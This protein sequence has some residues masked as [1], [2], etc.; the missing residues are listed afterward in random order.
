[1]RAERG[2][3]GLTARIVAIAALAAVVT[4]TIGGAAVVLLARAPAERADDDPLER[5]FSAHVTF[6]Q[7]RFQRLELASRLLAE[8]RVL[9]AALVASQE[10]D[11]QEEPAADEAAGDEAGEAGEPVELAELLRRRLSRLGCDVALLV[12]AD[13]SVLARSDSRSAT[14]RSSGGLATAIG[15]PADSP[16]AAVWQEEGRLYYAARAPMPP[17]FRYY[18][19][20]AL[21][22]DNLLALEIERAGGAE[23]SFFASSAVGPQLVGSSDPTRSEQLLGQLGGLG[24]P[25]GLLDRVVSGDGPVPETT[26]AAAA[27]R[28]RGRLAPLDGAAGRPVGAI[29]LFTAVAETGGSSGLPVLL[30]LAAAPLVGL[31]L[32]A[33][34]ALAVSRR[35]GGPVGR[36]T[37][38]VEAVRAGDLSQRTSGFASGALAPLATA[39]DRL[40]ADL[41]ERQSLAAVAS[42]AAARGGG[43]DAGGPGTGD[44]VAGADE[45]EGTA[46]RPDGGRLTLLAVDLRRFA[47]AA[48][49]DAEET[50]ERWRRD[51]RR[52]TAEVAA[53]GGR[54]EGALAH[55]LLASFAGDEADRRALSAAARVSVGLAEREHA[56]DD[57]EPPALALAAGKVSHGRPL[58]TDGARRAVA[59]PVLQ[60]LESLLREAQ[61][62]EM[63]LAPPLAKALAPELRRAG[64]EARERSGLLSPRPIPVVDRAAAERLA[65]L[66]APGGDETR[67][68][69]G[70]AH[71]APATPS[72]DEGADPGGEP[73]LAELS[74]GD[75]V[76]G[77]FE[78][79]EV[80]GRGPAAVLLRARDREL[81]EVVALKVLAPGAVG[82]ALDFEGLDSPLQPVRRL[83]H[84]GIARTYDYGRAGELAFFAREP[85]AGTSLARLL[86]S[87]GRLPAPA[88][89]GLARQLALAVG[90][91]HRDGL[92]HGRLTPGN[93]VVG[94]D[95]R[96]RI[97][98]FGVSMA[99]ADDPS[100]AA[101]PGLAPEGGAT[102]AGDVYAVAAMTVRAFTGG[103]PRP[104]EPPSGEAL[105][106]ELP[107]PLRSV[108]AAA[109]SAEPSQRPADGDELARALEAVSV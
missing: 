79:V 73:A 33:P 42:A 109:L 31:L 2:S 69:V 102:A 32:A 108:L 96:A 50:V 92:A 29:V 9:I 104:V 78:I 62:G 30:A 53:A 38:T 6:Q 18:A 47:V 52:F 87:P 16:A 10:A 44:P 84:P 91:V 55:R 28:Y 64:V 36:L 23:V 21:A 63:V 74:P 100:L 81:G 7:E 66:P 37:E 71:P 59:G 89:L 77:R 75:T 51:V 8:D 20:A 60:L 46:E 65:A 97:T 94:A 45:G 19:V 83:D 35:A 103:W 90:S 56:F 58:L 86:E 4:A 70:M 49:D 27:E 101:A 107:G 25:G 57:G 26:L 80:L 17:D 99:V 72:V 93:V 105:P 61:P 82:D 98:D 22:V 39:L 34:L 15:G 12:D 88:A 85:V 40:F 13:G 106:D 14:P 67:I 43:P 54:F 3:S 11:E 48:V 24:G 68:E 76:G 1:M 5:S 95:G 41:H